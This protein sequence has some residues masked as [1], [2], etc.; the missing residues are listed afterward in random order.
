MSYTIADMQTEISNLYME[1]K[2]RVRI[3]A[4]LRE[5]IRVLEEEIK[6]LTKEE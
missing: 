5:R 1:C 4:E 2:T 3:E 6:R